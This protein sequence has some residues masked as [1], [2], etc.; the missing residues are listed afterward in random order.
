[1]QNRATDAGPHIAKQNPYQIQNT[2]I[3]LNSGRGES[4]GAFTDTPP[5]RR[6]FAGFRR[7]LAGGDPVYVERAKPA[8]CW[9]ENI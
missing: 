9:P 6:H 3:K 7:T 4:G 5:E 1:M 2:R 8:T